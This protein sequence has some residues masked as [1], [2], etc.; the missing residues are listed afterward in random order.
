MRECAKVWNAIAKLSL[1]DDHTPNSG[2]VLIDHD[3]EELKIDFLWNV[4]GLDKTDI[5]KN[6]FEM[7]IPTPDGSGTSFFILS[8]FLCLVSRAS[9]ILTLGRTDQHSLDQLKAAIKIVSC[10]IY[11]YLDAGE[12][13]QARQLAENVYSLAMSK[14][15][16]IKICT[17]F[18]IDIFE[19][20]PEDDRFNENFNKERFPR[21]KKA[22][23][24][25]RAST[26]NCLRRKNV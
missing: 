21:M 2:I 17:D 12:E 9:N 13:K 4:Q 6:R 20:I 18:D 16:G 26:I 8:P 23:F 14:T 24:D 15:E 5:E 19:A 10:L 1:L 25:R 7:L 22:L 11:E 3:G